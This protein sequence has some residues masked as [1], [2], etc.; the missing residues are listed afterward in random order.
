[1][2]ATG[3]QRDVRA[4][5]RV[6]PVPA[7]PVWPRRCHGPGADAQELPR[8]PRG[9]MGLRAASCRR[10]GNRR[11]RVISKGE[12]RGSPRVF[13]ATPWDE[14]VW[15]HPCG[16][17]G[18]TDNQRGRGSWEV[19]VEMGSRGSLCGESMNSGAC[20]G[21]DNDVCWVHCLGQ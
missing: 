8:R 11:P 14:E 12:G 21:W 9:A 4:T 13:W 15:G 7:S 20:L 17:R 6:A 18:F 1:M 5:C 3:R 19:R 16:R 10:L 2:R